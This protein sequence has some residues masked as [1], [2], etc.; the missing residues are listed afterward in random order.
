MADIEKII[1]EG[2]AL[3]IKK[4]KGYDQKLKPVTEGRSFV[5]FIKIKDDRS[6]EMIKAAYMN[7]ASRFDEKRSIAKSAGVEML[8]FLSGTDQI[9]SA[10]KELAPRAGEDFLIISNSKKLYEKVTGN[11]NAPDFVSKHSKKNELEKELERMS[12]SRL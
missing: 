2:N 11:L 5:E 10:I 8:L 6:V 4:A 3:I 9:G 1:D 7:A 12:L